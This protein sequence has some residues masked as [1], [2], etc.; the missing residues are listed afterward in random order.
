M[1]HARFGGRSGANGFALGEKL[2]NIPLSSYHPL[3]IAM[4]ALVGFTEGYDLVMT[5]S[6]LVWRRR[7]RILG[8][9]IYAGWRPALSP[10]VGNGPK[11]G[12]E[13]RMYYPGQSRIL[14]M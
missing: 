12:S 14:S 4:V 3:I 13:C 5:G 1:V 9:R 11:A 10:A 6:L 2:D 8:I 7:R